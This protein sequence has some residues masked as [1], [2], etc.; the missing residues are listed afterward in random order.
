MCVLYAS[1]GSRVRPIP[2]G[3]VAMGTVVQYSLF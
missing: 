1:F 2:F 3:S